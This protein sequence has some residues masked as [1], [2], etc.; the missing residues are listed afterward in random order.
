MADLSSLPN[1]YT[2]QPVPDAA[3]FVASRGGR[4]YQAHRLAQ[5][6][7]RVNPPP[8]HLSLIGERRFG[9]TS[10]LGYLREK[11][12][13]TPNRCVVVMDLLGLCPQSPEGFYAMLTR[14]L[15]RTGE[16]QDNQATLTPL[17]FEDFLHALS[18]SNR[19][20][21]LFI[22][23]FDLVARERR[24]PREFFD[25]L[26]CAAGIRSL[27]LVLA[28]VASVREIAHSSASASPFFNIFEKE[29]LNLLSRQEAEALIAHPPGG[30]E[31]LDN[32]IEEIL[33]LAGCHPYFLQ[34]ACKCAW[35]LRAESGGNL[36]WAVL[37]STF[38]VKAGDHF[39]YIWEH[40]S[41][42]EQRTLCTLVR[43]TRSVG[44]GLD[45]LLQRGYVVD[46]KV[47]R[48]NGD[49]LTQ[50]VQEQCPAKSREDHPIQPTIDIRPAHRCHLALVVGVNE[51]RH[52]RAGNYYLPRLQYAE[53][54]ALEM[55]ALL[56]RLDYDVTLLTGQQATL[57]AIEQAFAILHQA[58]RD[59]AQGDS[60]FVFHF[61]G[62]GQMDPHQDETA[63]L[64][65][66]DTNP[67]HSAATGLNMTHLV[68]GLLPLVRM[69]HTLV[70][71]DA[72]HA[73]FAAG[74]SRDLGAVSRLP[75][76]AQQ[77]FSG[78]RGRMVL[79]ACAGEALA[80]E[81]T[82]L[83]H[84]VFTHYVLKHW[85]DLDGHHLPD[86]ITFGSLVDYVGQ[87]IPQY[88][89]DLPLPVYNGVGMGGTV[90]LRRI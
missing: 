32:Y 41:P 40:R 80:R 25:S 89:P 68:H 48:L 90:I 77:L 37:R 1:P 10:L 15:I 65:L 60:C 81:K 23:E 69:N 19:R 17:D 62:H 18:R 61:S 83:G 44:G 57:R 26:R 43:G 67:A 70:L 88:H 29:H 24:F 82:E 7:C 31:G 13:T 35:D 73:G 4:G 34:M 63:Y 2:L 50:F 14:A 58:T 53:R 64:V 84:G 8:D 87:A 86:R 11:A 76:V 78:L 55:A 28:S 79:A 59:E 45:T 49:G 47:P 21:I 20:L 38:R 5:N 42:E 33:A 66:H 9:K 75:N 52:E 71:L 36:D 56:T 46:G 27:T 72:C 30:P 22:D 12:A 74:V 39:Q 54:D 85:R 6:L 3:Y 51:Y 16:L